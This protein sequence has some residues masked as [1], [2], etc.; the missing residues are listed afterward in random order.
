[1]I[2]FSK[3][4]LGITILLLLIWQ[5][6]WCYRFFA[7]KPQRSPFT[8]YSS[9]INDFAITQPAGDGKGL[10]RTDLSGRR[11][12]EAQFDSILPM[13]Y[14]RQLL[15]DNRLPDSIN[16]TAINP[17]IIQTENFNYRHSPEDINAPSIGLY[18]LLE[19]MS[20]RVDLQMPDDVFRITGTGIEFIDIET[21]SLKGA[22]SKLFTEAMSKKG[23]RFPAT[24]ISGN[25]TTRKEYDEGYIMLDAEHRLFHLKQ[26]KGK[27][28]VRHIELP[29]GLNPKYIFI[30]EFRNK[31]TLGFLTDNGNHFYV[32]ENKTYDVK[33]VDI[34]SFNPETDALVILGNMFDWTVRVAST[35]ADKYYAVDANDYSQIKSTTY[36]SNYKELPVQLTFTDYTD[37]YV[38]PRL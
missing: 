24:R 13:F 26:V 25:P 19:S 21:N 5:L 2:R 30:T 31:K 34:P 17:R 16:G 10:E 37:K 14:Y 18:P 6:P 7:S 29:E 9:V 33:K 28:Y 11:Y 27:P 20:G 23:F 38:K 12:T 3:I 35:D 22:K 1:M 36:E 15:S 8:M 32:L 4:L